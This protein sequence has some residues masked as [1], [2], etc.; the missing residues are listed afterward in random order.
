MSDWD[1]Y[2]NEILSRRLRIKR[3]EAPVGAL[4]LHVRSLGDV[5]PIGEDTPPEMPQVGNSV[6]C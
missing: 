4:G 2:C 3:S 1:A 6:D 5:E